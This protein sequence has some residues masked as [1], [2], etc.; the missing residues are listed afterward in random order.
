MVRALLQ[1]GETGLDAEQTRVQGVRSLIELLHP[2]IEICLCGLID[3]VQTSIELHYLRVHVKRL[4]R[5]LEILR[6]LV[7]PP[8]AT[9]AVDL[10]T[11][12]PYHEI[13]A[14]AFAPLTFRPLGGDG[15]LDF[16]SDPLP[17]GDSTTAVVL[18][19]EVLEHFYQDP[20]FALREVHRILQPGGHLVLSTPNLASFRAVVGVLAHHSPML[21]GKFTP[22][23]PPHVHE[24][25]PREVRLLLEAAGF[26]A[27]VWTDNSYH[28][29]TPAAVVEWL[30]SAGF[31]PYER[32]DTIFAVATKKGRPGERYPAELYDGVPPVRRLRRTYAPIVQ[33]VAGEVPEGAHTGW[34]GGP[35]LVR[36]ERPPR[37]PAEGEAR[38]DAFV[39]REYY[40]EVSG[41]GPDE[42]AVRHY[43]A[44]G[45]ARG[46]DPHP[47]FSTSYYVAINDDVARAGMNPLDHYIRVGGAERRAFHPLFDSAYYA[48]RAESEG[49]T[50][51]NPLLH[52]LRIGV[53]RRWSPH[54]LVDF[55]FMLDGDPELLNSGVD[56]I[57]HCLRRG[58]PT[59][60]FIDVQHCLK[61]RPGVANAT[62]TLLAEGTKRGLSPHPLFDPGYYLE[63]YPDVA[64]ADLDPF[65][66]YVTLGARERRSPHPLFD[67]AYYARECGGDPAAERNGLYHF[68]MVGARRGLSPHP[69]F[70]PHHYARGLAK[71]GLT[72][73]NPLVHFLSTPPVC[74]PNPAFSVSAYLGRHIPAVDAGMNPLLHFVMRGTRV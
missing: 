31:S 6:D 44:R 48:S 61:Q 16:E 2:S 4:D 5:T 69:L 55:D 7:H 20:M 19:L 18:L 63:T 59:H 51:R 13:M 37:L 14:E 52:F 64:V 54:L 39:D 8:G 42:D 58:R 46:L 53:H 10:G 36:V 35:V 22:G 66:H 70:D 47:L 3:L 17:L 57:A 74:D 50:V 1:R 60:P 45:A 62:L 28:R 30:K 32:E 25:V 49:H 38:L 9:Q 65:L 23:N 24:F 40:A 33:A 26:D 11:W 21:Y 72:T 73:D 12:T 29:E 56:P 71:H 43:M 15:S 68:L 41:I 34:T 27:R 67:P